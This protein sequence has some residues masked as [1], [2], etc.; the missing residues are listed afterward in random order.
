[1]KRRIY[2]LLSLSALLVFTACEN[3]STGSSSNEYGPYGEKYFSEQDSYFPTEEWRLATPESQ[4]MDSGKLIDVF[5][6]LD[7][8]YSNLHSAIIIRNGYIVAEKY[9][10]GYT[11]EIKQ[12]IY[13]V[14]KSIMSSLAGIAVDK[15]H[16]HLDT[17]LTD[18]FSDYSLESPKEKQDITLEHLLKMRSGLELRYNRNYF[19]L[20][21]PLQF[22]LD[23][24]V[25]EEPDSSYNYSGA[26]SHLISAMIQETSNT[27]TVDFAQRYLFDPLHIE[28]VYFTELNG[29]AAGS[30]GLAMTPRDMGKIGLL[31]LNNGNWDGEQVVPESWIEAST[32]TTILDE[33][34]YDSH[35]GYQWYVDTIEDETVYYAQGAYGQYIAVMPDLDLVTVFTS[36]YSPSERSSLP[37]MFAPIIQSVI[38]DT[39]IEENEE[40]WTALSEYLQPEA[41]NG[42]GIVNHLPVNVKELD[43]NRYNLE[44]NDYKWDEI[45]FTF[46]DDDMILSILEGDKI[47]EILIGSKSGPRVSHNEIIGAVRSEGEWKEDSLYIDFDRM[48]YLYSLSWEL[49]FKGED[50]ERLI[51]TERISYDEETVIEGEISID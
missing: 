1:M 5:S 22:M 16:L 24:P 30:N 23:L 6:E 15:E 48:E 13:S 41:L 18:V 19:S 21:D 14:T 31:Y 17:S 9:H 12:W 33:T 28:N 39:S 25:K 45:T 4:G 43:G 27:R 51:L 35:Y 44:P 46:N 29:I 49:T 3:I 40:K 7:D 11:P 32:E 50:F 26:D 20:E 36:G 37:R 47:A 8:Y 42:E 2:T 10:K 34:L 38:S